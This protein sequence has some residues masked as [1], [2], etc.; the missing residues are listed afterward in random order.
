[1]SQFHF[2]QP[3][4]ANA[5]D[6]VSVLRFLFLAGMLILQ[7]M[8][9][10]S[11]RAITMLIKFNTAFLQLLGD[12]LQIDV[13]TKLARSI[14]LTYQTF[15]KTLD[16]DECNFLEYAVCPKCHSIFSKADVV[17]G[18]VSKCNFVRWPR[19]TQRRMRRPCDTQLHQGR[20]RLPKKIFCYKKVKSYLQDYVRQ[21]NFLKL[22]NM[23]RDREIRRDYL[24]D[25]Y[26]GELWAS[27]INNYLV[28]PTNLYGMINVDW[29]QPYKHTPYSIGAIYM[30]IL[31]LPR[32]LRFKE[33]NVLL[34]GIIPG[35]AE[36]SLHLNS[37]L[38]PLVDE[39]LELDEGVHFEDTAPMGNYYRLR[40]FGCSSDLPATRKLGGFLSFNAEYG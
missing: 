17:S 4:D 14:P 16:V 39:L 21:P 31:N 5:A 1:M 3:A 24:V 25:V 27:E 26:D 28:N 33:E 6:N 8:A 38:K 23:W 32:S 7:K 11:D 37:Y 10:I 29:F 18:R 36:P 35:P 40:L 2:R 12:I 9:G 19:H 30:V 22:C 34:I 13:V 20:T 15:K